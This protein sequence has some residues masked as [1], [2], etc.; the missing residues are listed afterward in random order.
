MMPDTNRGQTAIGRC[1]LNLFDGCQWRARE[2]FIREMTVT[3]LRWLDS[4]N[5][6]EMMACPRLR[7]MDLIQF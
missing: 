7:G 3:V 5:D 1:V 6:G 4:R 2:M